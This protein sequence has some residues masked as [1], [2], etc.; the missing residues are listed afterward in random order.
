MSIYQHF[1]EEER[2]FIDAMMDTRNKVLERYTPKLT[3]FL[4]PR[5]QEI[6]RALVPAD[7]ELT[8]DFWGGY[9]EAERK[10]ALFL[11]PYSDDLSRNFKVA[12][13]ELNYP[14]KFVTIEHRHLLGSLMGLGLKR[15]KFGDVL[16]TE[17]GAQFIVAEEIGDYVRFNLNQVGKAT[18]TCEPCSWDDFQPPQVEW[19]E[20]QGSVPSLRLDVVIAEI[21]RLTRSKAVDLVKGER[22]KVN[23]KV[24]D[25]PSYELTPGDDLSVRGFGRSRLIAIDGETRR[26]NL[27]VTFG[28]LK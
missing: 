10:R 2:P 11:P 22:V 24:I 9:K 6:V 7:G 12:L 19:E 4:D 13:Y 1:R 28:Q 23:W 3:D 20:R 15:E 27:W 14:A 26:G 5:Q 16:I 21:Y 18:V 17:S 8:V 25:K